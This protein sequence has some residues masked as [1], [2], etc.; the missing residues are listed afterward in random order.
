[1]AFTTQ[2]CCAIPR[3]ALSPPDNILALLDRSIQIN[4][5]NLNTVA[6]DTSI[7]IFDTRACT[8]T[9]SGAITRVFV[10]EH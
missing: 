4:L 5:R 1:M 6:S 8:Y 3:I 9:K 7:S 2:P 10:F